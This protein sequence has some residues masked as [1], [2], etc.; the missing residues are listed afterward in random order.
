MTGTRPPTCSSQQPRQTSRRSIVEINKKCHEKIGEEMQNPVRAKSNRQRARVSSSRSS[1]PSRG[2]R[3]ATGQ[4]HGN[5]WVIRQSLENWKERV[6]DRDGEPRKS[7]PG[8]SRNPSTASGSPYGDVLKHSCRPLGR[9]K[10]A[11]YSQIRQVRVSPWSSRGSLCICQHGGIRRIC[12]AWRGV[13]TFAAAVMHGRGWCRIS[14]TLTAPAVD[15]VPC[16]VSRENSSPP[17]KK[18]RCSIGVDF[19]N[20]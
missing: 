6:L 4:I 18:G 20:P 14:R 8:L 5:S 13:D 12:A 17:Q 3:G 9:Q 2:T 19:G 7:V 16:S 10:T 11:K 1:L 15:Q